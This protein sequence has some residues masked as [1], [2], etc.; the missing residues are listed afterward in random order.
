MTHI[1]DIT[2]DMELTSLGFVKNVLN[3]TPYYKLVFKQKRIFSVQK[4]SI[5]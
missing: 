5:H 4:F 1:I 2:E 3:K